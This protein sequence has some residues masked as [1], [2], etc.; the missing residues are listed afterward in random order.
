M[1]AILVE[2]DL[3]NVIVIAGS[4]FTMYLLSSSKWKRL[5]VVFLF[6]IGILV[7]IVA[8]I[9]AP[10]RLG[11]VVTHVQ[12]IQ[13]GVIEDEFGKGLQLRNI[14]IGVGSGGIFGKGIGESRLKQGY[15]VEVT[16]FT[17]SIAAVIFEELGFILSLLFVS[18]YVYLFL[19]IV[20][21]AEIQSD[22]YQRL[23]IWGIA[24]WFITQ[25]FLHLGANAALIPVKG[26]TLPFISYGGTSMLA[27]APAIGIV[28]R[29][30]KKPS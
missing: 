25:S 30:A 3:G 26:I 6:V 20:N 19:L 8:I 28:I 22:P 23:V 15:F 12:F 14:L 21:I 10:Y 11:R 4:Y 16:A 1:M 5:D 9:A 24:I 7:V 27:L 17:D 29:S 2:P 18:I 13:T